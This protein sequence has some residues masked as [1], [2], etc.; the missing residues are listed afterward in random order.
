M[1]HLKITQIGNSLG[2]VFPKEMLAELK[3]QKGDTIAVTSAPGGSM[4]IVAVSDPNFDAQ[5]DAAQ[6]VMRK[7][8]SALRELAK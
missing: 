2:A 1:I 4:R 7:R 5:M 6:K 8:R 3:A